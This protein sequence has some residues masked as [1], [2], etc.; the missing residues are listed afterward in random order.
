[1][2]ASD[3]QATEHVEI[4][5][6]RVAFRRHGAGPVLLLLHGGLCDG[7]VWRAELESFADE[8]LVVAWDTPGCGASDDPPDEFRMGDFAECLI[9]F[10]DALGLGPAHLLGHSWGTTLALEVCRQRPDLVRTLILVG[11]YAGWAGSLP[12]EEVRARLESALA[13]ADAP[14][15][16]RSASMPGLFSAAMPPERAEELAGIMAEVRAA[17]TRAMAYAL[18]EADLRDALPA[19]DVPT[20]LVHGSEDAR[21][22]LPVVEDLHR[23]LP[24]STI[25]ILPG[26][27]HECFFE[28]SETFA[29]AVRPFLSA[30]G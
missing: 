3:A 19:I 8:F 15:Q 24:R 17:G 30:D 23:A 10:I 29:T 26:L 21:S 13:A 14:A 18:A 28:S 9:G 1:V 6:L 16:I 22:P 25:S 4:S 2:S 5:S 11:P 12:A 27:G 20:L 7:R